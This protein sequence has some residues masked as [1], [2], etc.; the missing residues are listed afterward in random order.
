MKLNQIDK[1][2]VFK[3]KKRIGRGLG[4]GKGKTSGSGH[5]G[6][7]ARSGVVINGFEGGQMPLHMRMPKHGFKSKS[8]LR[9]NYSKNRLY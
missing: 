8:K 2:K 7:K 3:S 9:K 4:S 5:K 1:N 6:Q